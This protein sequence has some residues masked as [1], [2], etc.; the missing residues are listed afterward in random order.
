[1]Y[2]KYCGQTNIDNQ[3]IFE[4]RDV[5]ISHK[6]GR[7]IIEHE[8]EHHSQKVFFNKIQKY[9]P[10]FKKEKKIQRIN[11]CIRNSTKR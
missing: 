10:I 11:A 1:M 4:F 7:N 9:Q 8:T 3:I 5:L 2:Y 6:K